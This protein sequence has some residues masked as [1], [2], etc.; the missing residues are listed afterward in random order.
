MSHISD[1]V[2]L[3]SDQFTFHQNE[4]EYACTVVPPHTH[5]VWRWGVIGT[6]ESY[7]VFYSVLF[8]DLL[9]QNK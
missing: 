2:Y 6:K 7:A 1:E 3:G 8:K 5:T 4:C 9:F